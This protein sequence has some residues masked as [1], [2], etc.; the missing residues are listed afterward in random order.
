MAG[1]EIQ[2]LGLARQ[3]RLTDVYLPTL[4]LEAVHV[5]QGKPQDLLARDGIGN[6]P[7]GIRLTQ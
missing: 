5:L 1:E 3:L 6:F 2:V 7:S 4:K